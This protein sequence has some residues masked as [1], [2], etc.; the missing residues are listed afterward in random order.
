MRRD[1]RDIA[2]SP[3]PQCCLANV[4]GRDKCGHKRLGA[5]PNEFPFIGGG[6]IEPEID[7]EP[8]PEFFTFALRDRLFEQLAVQIETDCHDVAALGGP[9]N[10]ARAANFQVAHRDA[11]TRTQRAVLLDSAD[12]FARLAN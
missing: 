2:I 11:K 6:K 4:T 1:L 9:E 5:E 12:S 10:A 8:E 7:I 3:Y